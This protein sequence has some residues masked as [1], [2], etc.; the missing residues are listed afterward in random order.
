MI[1]SPLSFQRKLTLLVMAAAA[2]GLLMACFGLALYERHSFRTERA[3]ELKLLA[4]TLAANSAASLVF[5]DAVTAGDILEA[6]R[7]DEDIVAVRLYDK[8]H[9]IFAEYL[10]SNLPSVFSI[11]HPPPEGVAFTSQYVILTQ[12][13]WFH[14]ERE[15]TIVLLSN[16][17]SLRV[18]YR[19]Y[20]L[21]AVLV[22]VLALL[23]TALV[24]SRLLRFA[25]APILH[26]AKVA[27]KVTSE[28]DYSLRAKPGAKDEIGSLI[29]SFN[30]M[31]DAIQQRDNALQSANDELESRVAQRTSA[32]EKEISER[33]QVEQTLSNERQV[34]HALIDNVPDFMYV[35]DAGCRFLLGNRAVARQMGA[36]SSEALIGKT[37][38]DF[39]PPEL[40]KA[41]FE[42]EQ[43]V[44]RSGKAEV[45]RE[46]VGLDSSGNP[47]KVLTT[48]VPLH[49]SNGQVIGLVGIGRDITEMKRTEDLL[50]RTK[51]ALSTERQVLRALIDNIPDYMFVKDAQSRFVV[52][53][54]ALA[55][56]IGVGSAEEL[57]GKTE[58]AFAPPELANEFYLKEQQVIRTKE[59]LLSYEVHGQDRGGG[60][61]WVS[62]SNVP[63]LDEHGE[64][65]GI[66]GVARDIT[67]SK[68]LELEWQ[69]AKD[70]A[71]SANRAKSEFLANMSHEIR[72]PL[73]GIIGMT[74]LAL[75][76][77]LSQEQREYLETVK[78][79]ADSLLSVINDILDFS[80]VE[81]GKLELE[82]RDFN[83]RE[84]L[85]TALKT[86]AL[87]ADEKGLELLCQISDGVPEFVCGDSGRLR[88]VV[89]N[90]IGNAIKFTPKGQVQLRVS[91]EGSNGPDH[92]LHF[93]V[94]DT[95]IGIPPE[96]QALVFQP[97]SQADSS[98]TRKFGGTG[99]GLSISA[100]FIALMGGRIWVESKPGV[101]S[102]FHFTAKLKPSELRAV[103]PTDHLR[104]V[105]VMVVDDNSTNLR[106]LSD[107]L[108]R[109]QMLP[110]LAS[111]G[112]EA[113]ASLE[114]AKKQSTLPRLILVDLHMPMMDGFSLIAHIRQHYSN[115]PA[116]IVMLTS[117]HHQDDAERCRL[118]GVAAYLLKPIRKAE[119]RDALAQVLDTPAVQVCPLKPA[120]PNRIFAP[121]PSLSI[122]V[123]E[124]NAVNQRLIAR[125]LEKRGHRVKL[126]CNGR[127]ALDFVQQESFDLVFMD[128]QMPEMDG[129]TATAKIRELERATGSGPH[130]PI[131]AL[132]AHAM[133]GDQER[134]LASGMDGYLSKP[135][136]PQELDETIIRQI[137]SR[138]LAECDQPSPDHEPA[139]R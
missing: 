133:K 89:I 136:R 78:F 97:F 80:K 17:N 14:G 52:A 1:R 5:N 56:K 32:L 7:T 122:L 94:S 13:V 47:S 42:D 95:G 11:P 119:L 83:L 120:V 9:R 131:V 135:I 125:L 65:T 134:F 96:K 118:L 41:F 4:N 105:R 25:I 70:A 127:E 53:N 75:D 63:L 15:G 139:S 106:I 3:S 129:I 111:G 10:R 101:G 24:S 92:L 37:D 130:I 64:A 72:T 112:A 86:L 50:L 88:Q 128:I 43:R 98:T 138:R 99:L 85:E 74:D 55:R 61:V 62:V 27:K 26:L 49:D 20:A 58:A 57:I 82:L 36:E 113:I 123:A 12:P 93:I 23:L 60:E 38:F 18:K 103:V 100:S 126:A 45:N 33:K 121:T 110:L 87:R 107:L 46:E 117:S 73:N 69:R 31:L 76:T 21:I 44:M 68:K 102:D 67:Q 104:G 109:W 29:W 28:A 124:D 108:S 132:T 48:Q 22:L 54:A 66:A 40:A 8:Q 34:L 59:P 6:V 35:K 16:L 77:P 51:E 81:A 19:E 84:S 79:S 116:E 2:L 71:E 91:R 30:D 39:Y 114:L 137:T 115:A 90:L